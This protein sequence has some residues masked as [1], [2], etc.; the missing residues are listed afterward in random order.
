LDRF[1]AGPVAGYC[2]DK[3]ELQRN[4]RLKGHEAKV[5]NIHRCLLAVGNHVA[6]EPITEDG[7]ELTSELDH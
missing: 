5:D 7:A 6:I 3:G 2:G 4:C 1:S